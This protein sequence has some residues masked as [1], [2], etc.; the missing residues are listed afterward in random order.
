MSKIWP[1]VG[2]LKPTKKIESYILGFKTAFTYQST[3]R[4]YRL[5]YSTV[6]LMGHLT[7]FKYIRRFKSKLQL[8]HIR[9]V[10]IRG[11]RHQMEFLVHQHTQ[12]RYLKV[13]FV[14]SGGEI[15]DQVEVNPETFE[16]LLAGESLEYHFNFIGN[17]L[18]SFKQFFE[19]LDQRVKL[20]VRLFVFKLKQKVQRKREEL[21][22]SKHQI[23][24][25]FGQR[26]S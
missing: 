12:A 26:R 17:K 15:D 21:S 2:T 16:K 19:K 24:V 13:Y 20:Q 4:F 5:L 25:T 6:G 1:V 9:T 7:I 10:E 8:T 18:C 11:V 23:S 3:N 14:V 22:Y